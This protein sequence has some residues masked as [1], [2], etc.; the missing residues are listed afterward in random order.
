MPC[1]QIEK[2][3]KAGRSYNGHNTMLSLTISYSI[4][5]G[6]AV[7]SRIK[8]TCTCRATF[9]ALFAVPRV[10]FRAG[11][12]R[13]RLRPRETGASRR[14][15]GSGHVAG[16]A[17]HELI[18]SW[19]VPAMR[20]ATRPRW[21]TRQPRLVP[22]GSSWTHSESPIATC[23]ISCPASSQFQLPLVPKATNRG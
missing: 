1:T 15:G 14:P 11:A 20:R 4:Q 19:R 17:R 22:T 8:V 18:T 2:Y 5:H 3:A 6:A 21:P 9:H 13:Y 12:W 16:R 23:P 7:A 10:Q